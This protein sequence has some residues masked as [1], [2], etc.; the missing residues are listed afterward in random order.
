MKIL[1]V[2]GIIAGFAGG[3]GWRW[4]AGFAAGCAFCVLYSE[5]RKIPWPKG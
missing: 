5:F 2:L 4:I 1:P 3:Y